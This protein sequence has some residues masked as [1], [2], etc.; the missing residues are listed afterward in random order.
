MRIEGD[1]LYAK[2]AEPYYTSERHGDKPNTVRL[3]NADE[4][5]LILRWIRAARVDR[6]IEI[7]LAGG[8]EP[9]AWFRRTITFIE[10]LEIPDV[11]LPPDHMLMMI[12][13]RP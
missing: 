12:C 8:G 11:K 5:L 10:M 13:W 4:A 7:R 3:V 6:D 2:S 1:T 9:L